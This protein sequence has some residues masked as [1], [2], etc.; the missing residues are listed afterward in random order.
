MCQLYTLLRY[1]LKQKRSTWEKL[2]FVA[3][4][5]DLLEHDYREVYPD[6]SEPLPGGYEAALRRLL[7]ERYGAGR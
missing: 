3:H 6:D 4:V 5:L 2:L 1:L 7:E